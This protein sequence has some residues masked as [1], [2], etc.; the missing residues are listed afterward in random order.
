MRALTRRDRS[1]TFL[2]HVVLHHRAFHRT[3][4]I[5]DAL[6][7]APNRRIGKRPGIGAHRCVEN[8]FLT[9]RLIQRLTR[10]M[11]DAPNFDHAVRALVQELHESPVNF[12][13]FAAPVFDAHPRGS[14]RLIPATAAPFNN[15]TR[16]ASASAAA[17]TVPARSIS[18]TSAEPTTAASANPP[19]TDTCPGSEMPNPMAMGRSV[20][21]RT[22]RASAGNSSASCSFAPVTP[23]REIKY[24]NPLDDFAISAR[25]SSVDVGA[26]R[27]IVSRPREY[28]ATRYSSPSSGVRSVISTPSAP[29]AFAASPNFSSPICRTGLK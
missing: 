25:R 5:Q 9:V 29:A 22:R 13:D 20:T 1:L 27:K 18:S 28:I 17:S 19:S 7:Q 24:R 26:A 8:V 21:R 10:G 3:R 11:L 6:E 4:F 16:A 15:L 12:I 2:F 14:R 23:V